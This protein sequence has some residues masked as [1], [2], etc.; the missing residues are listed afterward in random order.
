MHT[1]I[2]PSKLA[3]HI[4][5][6]LCFICLLCSISCSGDSET[7]K[8]QKSRNN[9]IDVRDQVK[10]IVIED[11]MIGRI[12]WP[13]IIDK[14]LLIGD[15]ES[16]DQQIHLFDRNSFRYITSTA[17]KG[18]G[19]GEIAGLGCIAYD[20]NRRSFYVTD[21]GKLKIFSYNLDSVL[22]NP[23][24]KPEVKMDMK[25]ELFPDSYQYIDDT[26]CIG[27]VIKPIG[28]ND[29]KPYVAKWNMLTG[30]V[31]LMK[32]EHPDI[33]KARFTEAVSVEHNR[34]IQAYGRNDLLTICNL[35][36][37]L[38]CNIYGPKWTSESSQT[39]YF[40]NPAFCGDKII[41]TYSGGNYLTDGSYPTKLMIFNLDGNYLQTLETGYKIS[42]FC[43]DPD[44][45]RLILNMN[46]DI[47]FCYL[48]L[49]G[50][51][52]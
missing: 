4:A 38:I 46:D 40:R 35:D 30:E 7:E 24:Y 16:P 9:I 23:D 51:V 31:D 28:T 10:E 34:Y 3:K 11:V 1:I 37:E 6:S 2:S 32:Y 21:H 50:I 20:K 52:G 42:Y 12:A 43:Y 48:D 22:A 47:Q 29:F 41:V 15:Y 19:P 45:N 13:Y 36:G 8:Y 5:Q 39:S 26:L 25:A 33:R 14:Y 17:T 44:N 18:Q 27:R 49:N